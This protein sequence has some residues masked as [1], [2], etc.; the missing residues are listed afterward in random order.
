MTASKKSLSRVCRC[1]GLAMAALAI[2]LPAHGLIGQD[3]PP[4]PQKATPAPAIKPPATTPAKP[5][6]PPAPPSAIPAPDKPNPVNIVIE[7]NC[8][9]GAIKP[10]SG[11]RR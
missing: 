4:P 6:P 9:S 3:W 2:S 1:L 5:V 11:A 10:A 8:T 7:V